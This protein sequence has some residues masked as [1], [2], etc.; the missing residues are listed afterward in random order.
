MQWIALM[1]GSL[2]DKTN[3]SYILANAKEVGIT[4]V[5]M[6]LDGG[7]WSEECLL[8]LH[9]ICE[10]FTVGMPIHLNL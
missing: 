6:I 3:L 8:S 7:F 4:R 2:T 9:S 1:T 5:K 10:A